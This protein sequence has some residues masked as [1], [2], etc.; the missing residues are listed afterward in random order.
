VR[1]MTRNKWDFYID[2][3]PKV[4]REGNLFIDGIMLNCILG[5]EC[6]RVGL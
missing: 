4:S 1:D 3:K 5:N 6:V 2:F